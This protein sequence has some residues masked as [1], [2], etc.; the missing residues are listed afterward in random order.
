[1]KLHSYDLNTYL[2]PIWQGKTVY[3]ETVLFVGEEDEASLLFHPVKIV[4]VCNYGLTVCY[5]EGEDYLIQNGKIRRLKGSKIPYIEKDVYYAKEPGAITIPID[6]NKLPF[7][8]P[9]YAMFGEKN[10]FT[11]YQIAVTY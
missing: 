3:H 2:Y 1:M 9:R 4:Q 6:L 10:T 5:Q 7:P 8:E 11:D